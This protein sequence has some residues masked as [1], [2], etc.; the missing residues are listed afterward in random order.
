MIK[1]LL[2]LNDGVEDVEALATKALLTRAGINIETFTLENKQLIKTAYNT[3]V[4]VDLLVDDVSSLNY[5]FLVLPGGK[6]VFNFLG[7]EKLNKLILEF[8]NEN[9]LIA[10]ICAAPLFLNELNLLRDKDFVA[11]PSVVEEISGKYNS[12]LKV[13]KDG[14]IITSR[15][16]GTVYDF[17]FEIVQTLKSI[18]SVNDLQ[19]EIVY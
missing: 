12:D 17:V 7:N 9:K 19:E 4:E 18:E 15:S 10:A 5:E 6:H 2:L 13:I 16:A 14:N 3:N 11:F 1:G 8:N